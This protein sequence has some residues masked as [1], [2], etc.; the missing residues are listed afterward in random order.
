MLLVGLVK[1]VAEMAAQ[2]APKG[3]K[4]LVVDLGVRVAILL[5]TVPIIRY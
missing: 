2:L 4:W 3:I 5:Y 1:L